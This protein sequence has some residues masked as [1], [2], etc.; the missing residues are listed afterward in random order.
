V[1]EGAIVKPVA[2][3]GSDG[4]HELQEKYDSASRAQA[5]Y[6]N[7]VLGY[8]NPSMQTFLAK[9]EMMFVGTAD[10]HGEADTSFRAGLP[11][12]VRVLDENSCLS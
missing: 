10:K 3:P 5:F 2:L 6:R 8:L 1:N 4:E 11:G 12:F 7:Q 9:Q